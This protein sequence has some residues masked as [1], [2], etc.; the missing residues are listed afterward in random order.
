MTVHINAIPLM[1]GNG[2]PWH[3]AQECEA[4]HA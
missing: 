3:D 1:T 2:E 4:G